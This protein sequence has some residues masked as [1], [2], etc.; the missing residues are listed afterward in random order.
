M[1][2]R[3]APRRTYF[4]RKSKDTAG[5]RQIPS[6]RP[7]QAIDF[8]GPAFCVDRRFDPFKAISAKS[9]TVGCRAFTAA[10]PTRDSPSSE[11]RMASISNR[12]KY[13][14]EVTGAPELTRTFPHTA[15]TKARHYKKELTANGHS[16]LIRQ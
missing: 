13:I 5:K 9:V 16:G 3:V 11:S 14:V 7:N 10:L 1:S 2:H 8:A 6:P 4:T 12:S 15:A